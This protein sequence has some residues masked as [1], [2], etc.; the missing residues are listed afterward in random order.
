MAKA[1]V[2]VNVRGVDLTT[3]K[4]TALE[5]LAGLHDSPW[6]VTEVQVWGQ[7]NDPI[8]TRDGLL[9]VWS[10]DFTCETDME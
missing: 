5:R 4:E 3:M 9:P 6:T 1:T 10:A 8:S 7:E 2:R